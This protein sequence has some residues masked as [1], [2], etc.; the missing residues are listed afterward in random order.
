MFISS[1]NF[2]SIAQCSEEDFILPTRTDGELYYQVQLSICEEAGFSP[3]ISHETVHGHT[4]LKLVDHHLGITFLPT[5]F[6]EVTNANVKFIELNNIPQRAE[7]T[8][9][10]NLSNPNPSLRRFLELV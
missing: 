5:S 9:L 3:K 1:E 7:I 6:K 10:W 4:V 8:T 2:V